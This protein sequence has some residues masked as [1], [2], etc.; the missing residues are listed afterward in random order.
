MK[1]SRWILCGLFSLFA[2]LASSQNSDAE[3]GIQL[4]EQK[5][6]QSALPYLQRAAKAGNVEV[7]SCLGEMYLFG[8]GV[9]VDYTSALNMYRRGAEKDDAECLIGMGMLY[10]NGCGVEKDLTKAF[11]YMKKA[12]DMGSDGAC[13][14][15]SEFYERGEG[16]E[17]DLVKSLEYAERAVE[18]GGI[19]GVDRIGY[20][21]MQGVKGEPDYSKTLYYLTRPGFPYSPDTRLLVARLLYE[22]R[23]TSDI[24]QDYPCRYEKRFYD[25]GVTGKTYIAEAL[26]IVDKLVEEGHEEARPY[27]QQWKM[28]YEEL[29]AY[30]EREEMPEYPGGV[31]ALV[32]FISSQLRYPEDAYEMNIQGKVIV[33]FIIS[34]DGYI[35]DVHIKKSVYPSLDAEAIRVIKLMP[36]WKPGKKGGKNVEVQYSVPITFRF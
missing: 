11:M 36:K 19:L 23:G 9:V 34:K 35:S 28:K 32:S 13:Y 5:K 29:I 30:S 3:K 22:G 27:Q 21:Y 8:Q 7:L 20:M 18:N 6:Y 26:T 14:H 4:Y 15:L 25:K 16:C 12:A 24:L 2:L 1:N 31:N 33:G 17:I 10:H